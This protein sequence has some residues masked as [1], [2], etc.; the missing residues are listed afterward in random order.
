MLPCG[1]CLC[2]QAMFLGWSHIHPCTQMEADSYGFMQLFLALIFPEQFFL[3]VHSNFK[4]AL[5]RNSHTHSEKGCKLFLSKVYLKSIFYPHEVYSLKAKWN[6]VFFYRYN[7]LYTPGLLYR[8]WWNTL[9]IDIKDEVQKPNSKMETWFAF[10]HLNT[11]FFFFRLR[12]HW[13]F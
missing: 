12:L 2:L 10:F 7:A 11:F 6:N 8:V 1:L 4:R 9:C 3:Y 5:S 13:L